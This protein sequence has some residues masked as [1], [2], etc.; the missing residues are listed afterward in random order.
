MFKSILIAVVLCTVALSQTNSTGNKTTTLN[1]NTA[2]TFNYNTGTYS[3]T[4]YNGN[5][6]TTFDYGTKTYSR[7]AKTTATVKPI[8]LPSLDPRK[9]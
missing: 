5:T 6:A 1:G 7:T 4:T 3:T 9:H 2:T 8:E